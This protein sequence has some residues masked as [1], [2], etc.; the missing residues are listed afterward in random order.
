MPEYVVTWE[1]DI[2]AESPQKAAEMAFV[3]Q[4]MHDPFKIKADD[5]VVF[6]VS[7]GTTTVTIDLAKS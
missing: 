5:A 1:I 3:I 4:A 7:D 2:E 6:T